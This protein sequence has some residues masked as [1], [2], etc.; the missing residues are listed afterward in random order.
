MVG[1]GSS[2]SCVAD[3]GADTPRSTAVGLS[4]RR[5]C[6]HAFQEEYSDLGTLSARFE[7]LL[8]FLQNAATTAASP[9]GTTPTQPAKEITACMT[10]QDLTTAKLSMGNMLASSMKRL[11][12]GDEMELTASCKA[13]KVWASKGPS[14]HI[15][16]NLKD[17]AAVNSRKRCPRRCRRW[18]RTGSW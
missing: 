16:Q 5:S 6:V 3:K 4:L 18:R 7:A 15:Q 8:L 2:L 13:R 9:V 10:K 1:R 12:L 17:A 11:R 14:R